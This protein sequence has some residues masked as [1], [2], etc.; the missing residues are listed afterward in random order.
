MIIKD[1][2]GIWNFDDCKFNVR[3]PNYKYKEVKFDKLTEEEKDDFIDAYSYYKV[4]DISAD[5]TGDIDVEI[6]KGE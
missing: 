4:S 1:F 6:Y 2:F 3:L 5:V